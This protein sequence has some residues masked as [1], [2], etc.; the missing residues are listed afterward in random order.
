MY[1]ALEQYED[2][3]IKWA[4]DRGIV[5]NSTP[6]LQMLKLTSEMGELADNLAKKRDVRDDIGDCLVVLTIIAEMEGLSL[7]RCLALLRFFFKSHSLL[8]LYK[9]TWQLGLDLARWQ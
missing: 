8:I 7:A 4:E 9:M 3:T 6:Q 5:Q 1:R 2:M